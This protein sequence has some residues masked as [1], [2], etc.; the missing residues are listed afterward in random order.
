MHAA[1]AAST[2]ET[3]ASAL[4]STTTLRR[5]STALRSSPLAAS[6][7]APRDT[8]ASSEGPTPLRISTTGPPIATGGRITVA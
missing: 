4:P 3:P 5:A 7:I 2:S 6:E 8:S 1:I